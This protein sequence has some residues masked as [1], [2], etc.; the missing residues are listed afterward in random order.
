MV[1][2]PKL[3]V[4]DQ[5]SNI[6]H[7]DENESLKYAR[8]HPEE[9]EGVKTALGIIYYVYDQNNFPE[10]VNELILCDKYNKKRW[11]SQGFLDAAGKII[12]NDNL[13]SAIESN[14]RTVFKDQRC[15][16]KVLIGDDKYFLDWL[17]CWSMFMVRDY[18]RPERF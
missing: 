16:Y 8:G 14:A 11:P 4:G 15:V 17:N 3:K 2:Q 12:D 10:F 6:I 18:W 5:T 7:P 1:D 13:I 9:I